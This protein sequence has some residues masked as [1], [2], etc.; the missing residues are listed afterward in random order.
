MGAGNQSDAPK[1]ALF[2]LG[3]P[4]RILGPAPGLREINL[5]CWAALGAFVVLRIVVPAAIQIKTGVPMLHI[6]P[7]DFTY[8]YGDGLIANHYPLAGFYDY[9]L[10]AAT[11]NSIY[12]LSSGVYGMQ[13]YPPFIP[14]FFGFFARLPFAV[15][16]G[17][18]MLL[19]LILYITGVRAAAR[20]FFAVEPLKVS[21]I[22]CFALAFYPFFIA[23][24]I[25]GQLSAIAVFA[26]GVAFALERRDK[27]IQSGLVLSLIIY[28]PTL[29]LLVVPMLLL[30][31][32]MKS[33]LGFAAGAAVL[34]AIPTLVGGF[35]VWP[36]YLRFLRVYGKEVSF[37]DRSGMPLSKHVDLGSCLLAVSG[38]RSGIVNII[39]A[40]VAAVV[41]LSLAWLGW[42]SVRAG[43]PAGSLVWAAALTW[44]LLINVYVPMY[45]ASLA[46]LAAVLTLGAL[47]ELRWTATAQWMILLCVLTEIASWYTSGIAL[48]HGVQILSICIALFG[49]AQLW[50]L[51]KS[52]AALPAPE[53]AG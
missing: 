8:Y 34:L 19:S 28:K 11:Y 23:T 9:P 4:H 42:R 38:G 45:D 48:E 26:I 12:P 13:P 40:I 7:A 53:I 29:C 27:L 5:V 52:V 49:A 1:P 3:W 33:L 6:M 51:H 2:R 46:A 50:L 37:S 41:L 17:L 14:L 25:N 18:W 10:Q 36:S 43:R 15:A 39:L 31:R 32:R 22:L 21:L 20:S 30:T 24:M 44:T 16:F 35:A 47:K